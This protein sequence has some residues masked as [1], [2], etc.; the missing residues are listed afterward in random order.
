MLTTS[1][2]LSPLVGLGV[3][4]VDGPSER[5][6]RAHA[7]AQDHGR[8]E[9]LFHEHLDFVWRAAR[10]FGL[11]DSEAED[12]SQQAFVVASRRLGEIAPGR[13]RAFLFATVANLVAN[14]KR[15]QRRR[16][17]DFVEVDVPDGAV[18][19]DELLDRARARELADA[20]L[21]RMDAELRVAFVLCEVEE[22]PM[23]SVAEA[24]HVP[25]GTVASRLRRARRVF[26]EHA[27]RLTRSF[28]GRP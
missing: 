2:R 11:S 27:A 21:D 3:G 8:F 9:R 17:E 14:V 22:M 23:A 13:E 1:G 19:A 24:L 7:H 10:R 12:V 6:E 16:R 18:S 15:A 26:G 20:I 25:V 5:Q 4:A 28:G